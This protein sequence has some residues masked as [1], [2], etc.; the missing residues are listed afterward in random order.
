MKKLYKIMK[1]SI[2]C[3][4][5]IFIGNSLFRYYDYKTHPGLYLCQSAPWYLAIELEGVFTAVVVMVFLIIMRIIKK[6]TM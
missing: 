1:T 6:K 2:W 5:G 3:F 4:I